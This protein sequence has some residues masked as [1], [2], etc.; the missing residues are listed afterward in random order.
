MNQVKKLSGTNPFCP[1]D[2]ELAPTS[3]QTDYHKDEDVYMLD[4]A[5]VDH[6]V[7]IGEKD[8]DFVIDSR[9]EEVGRVKRDSYIKSYENEVGILN[10]LEK[11]RKTGDLSLFNQVDTPVIAS[12]EKDSL[13][14]PVQDVVDI[15][16]YQ[17]DKIDALESFKKG[18]VSFADLPDDL[19]GKMT[20]KEIAHL[21]DEE[22]LKYID[23]LRQKYTNVE[24]KGE[25][26]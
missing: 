22:I 24:K 5:N 10:I 25:N 12:H 19:K 4:F 26:E 17:V 20:M 9:V 15:T 21:S 8:T 1:I 23:G 18:A 2:R 16:R 11:V 3:T 14:R 13:G 7:K 6:I